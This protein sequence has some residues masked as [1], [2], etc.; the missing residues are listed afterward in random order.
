[1]DS[2]EHDQ[3]KASAPFYDLLCINDV[4]IPAL[5]RSDRARWLV[6]GA[7]KQY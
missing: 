3:K 2:V 1:M 4:L 7:G 5:D 6:M